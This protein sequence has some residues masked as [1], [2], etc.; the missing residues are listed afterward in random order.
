MKI[1]Y[2]ISIL[3]I[4]LTAVII[5]LINLAYVRTVTW[6][7]EQLIK[8]F[9]PHDVTSSFLGVSSEDDIDWDDMKDRLD[10]ALED[11]D[12]LSYIAVYEADASKPRLV[13]MDLDRI[14]PLLDGGETLANLQ[15]IVAGIDEG[16][17]SI[18][19]AR[20]MELSDPKSSSPR[21]AIGYI[22]PM[23]NQ[24]RSLIVWI[25]LIL[26]LIFTAIA[27]LMSFLLAGRITRPIRD[28]ASA[29]QEASEGNLDTA[30][31][32]RSRDEVGRLAR[33]FN[34]MIYQLKEKTSELEQLNRTLEE[35]VQRGIAELRR[36][37]EAEK[38]RLNGEVQRAREVQMG[39][40][41]QS[42]PQIEGLDIYGVCHSASEVGGDFFDYLRLGTGKSCLALGDVSG[43]GM[44]GAMNAV[45]AYG[46]L[47]A[48]TRTYSSAAATISELNAA[49]A[50]RFEE[51]TF[52]TLS[53]GI[54]D[55]EA[56]E[57]QLCNAGNP[58]PILLR[59]GKASLLELSGMPLGIIS[60]IEYDETVI[61]LMPGD[62]L[63]FYSDGISEAMTSDERM[64]G[65]DTLKELIENLPLDIN[66]QAIV[67]RILQEVREFVGDF[68]QSDDMTVIVLRVNEVA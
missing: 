41:P 8:Q 37:D 18:R 2:K 9:L 32:V 42:Q 35:R 53:L 19:D 12:D 7:T 45:M 60:E 38:Q 1:R 59:A 68:P 31:K 54:I 29:M 13:S 15:D 23:L 49:L 33:V 40:L 65:M 4:L 51:T 44:K 34:G 27:V 50:A 67:E 25:A 11:F 48:Q 28:L 43:K 63:V 3:M 64:Y 17:I 57:I 66:A 47:H 55:T 36:R 10:R 39:L 58:Y 52:T 22:F 61:A 56:K 26:I 62:V 6:A 24:M 14:Q 21:I 30:V 46:M 20:T 5:L 16:D